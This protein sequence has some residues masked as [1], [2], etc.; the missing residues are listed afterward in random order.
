MKRTL[1]VLAGAGFAV[2]LCGSFP[3]S[4]Q[5]APPLGV[6]QQFSV[7]GNSGVT[8][9]TGAGT[10]VTGDVGSSPTAS[11]SNFPPSSVSPPFILHLTNDLTVQQAH[12]D[13]I[14]AYDF[15]AT[16]GP[17]TVLAAQLNGA[18]LTSGIYS[19]AGGAADLAATGT[20][21][22][23]GP[24]IFV[25]QVDSALTANV[26]SS[27][28]GTANACNVFWRV[29]TSATLNGVSFLGNVFADA[30]IT[31]GSGSNVTGRTIAGHGPTGA[32]TMAGAGGN[33][34]GGCASTP[35]PP[36][37]TPTPGGPTPTPTPR[38]PSPTPTP[39]GGVAPVSTLSGWGT[40]VLMGL[41][42]LVGF[43]AMRRQ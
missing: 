1:T 38:G 5:T 19:F 6:V 17:G 30:S 7:L 13:A 32:V 37:P 40:I 11:I 35:P 41:L 15:L 8:G 28:V 31:V 39:R 14:V 25:F 22:L 26:G 9:S 29:G 43:A 23:N 3:A 24:G 18:V 12:A 36:T 20:L 21:T 27:V 34:I 10:V 33:S 2:S 42:A 4:A 16:E